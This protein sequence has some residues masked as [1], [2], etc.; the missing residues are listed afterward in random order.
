[1]A[2]L[3]TQCILLGTKTTF[4]AKLQLVGVFVNL[5][6][7]FSASR[8]PDA[9]AITPSLCL[10]FLVGFPAATPPELKN[11]AAYAFG[12][13]ENRMSPLAMAQHRNGPTHVTPSVHLAK[14]IRLHIELSCPYMD[15]KYVALC[16]PPTC[17]TELS[18]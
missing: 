9:D 15:D 4:I 12:G 8:L 16:V 2:V 13:F 1:M 3:L 14:R 7:V 17:I 10:V 18:L 5:A 11:S 6:Y